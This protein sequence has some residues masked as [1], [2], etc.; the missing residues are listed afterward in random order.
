[1]DS[2]GWAN[3]WNLGGEWAATIVAQGRG[4]AG[5]KRAVASSPDLSTCSWA[6]VLF[7]LVKS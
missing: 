1:M 6:V 2:W 7:Q 3:T 5:G 4:V